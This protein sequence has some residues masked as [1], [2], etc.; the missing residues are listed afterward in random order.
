MKT[1]RVGAVTCGII[2]IVIGILFLIHLFF[3][4]LRYE[5]ILR[6]WPLILISI[7]AEM[8][9]ANTTCP[10]DVQIKYDIA[11]IILVFILVLFAVSMG[12]LEFVKENYGW[13]L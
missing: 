1:R 13:Y 3:P 7:G 12:V 6:G 4:G 8:L 11:A 10:E 5:Y 2:L 9:A